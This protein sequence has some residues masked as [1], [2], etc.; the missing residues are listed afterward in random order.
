M[1]QH[2]LKRPEQGKPEHNEDKKEYQVRQPVRTQCIQERSTQRHGDQPHDSEDEHN[3]Y[4]VKNGLELPVFLLGKVA[5]RHRHD[6]VDTGHKNGGKTGTEGYEKELPHA[7]ALLYRGEI[8]RR[9]YFC[10]TNCQKGIC[11]H[12][13]SQGLF[14][15]SR[16]FYQSRIL[17]F[18]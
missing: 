8:G 17:I 16:V 11:F 13:S 6:G 3:A 10:C 7:T 4:P 2:N 9:C 12:S 14:C 15:R 18:T 1:R 5:H